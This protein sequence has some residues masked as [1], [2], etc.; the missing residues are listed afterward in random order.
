MKI[1]F[2]NKMKKKKDG[3]N[4]PFK[5]EGDKGD[6]EENNCRSQHFCPNATSN[7]VYFLIER[8]IRNDKGL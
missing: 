3:K 4:R 7:F 8:N 5:R 1:S 2:E 6:N